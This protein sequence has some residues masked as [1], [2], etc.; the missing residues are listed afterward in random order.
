MTSPLPIPMPK[1]F[2]ECLKEICVCGHP[3]AKHAHALHFCTDIGSTFYKPCLCER[4]EENGKT[5][6]V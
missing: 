3:R 5:D 1:T 2:S 4:F 6:G